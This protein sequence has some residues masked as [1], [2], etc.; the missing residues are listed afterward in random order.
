MDRL[1]YS[2]IA[3]RDLP[4]AAPLPP[5]AFRRTVERLDLPDGARVLDLGCGKATLSAW[6]AERYGATC[7]GVERSPYA[8]ASARALHPWRGALDILEGDL[9]GELPPGPWDLV[10]NVGA[11]PPGGQR[12]AVARW[13]SVLAPGGAL[14]IGDL[15]WKRPP[16]PDF[17]AVLGAG[18][19]ATMELDGLR[20]LG[21]PTHEEVASD[22][23]FRAYELALRG[24]IEAF[25]A[26]HPADPDADA[27][28]DRAR[29]WWEVHERWGADTLGFALLLFGVTA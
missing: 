3:H 27:M 26:E 2:A 29:A 13:S 14:L 1:R 8:L 6:I 22:A 10:V 20:A 9:A 4:F 23:D 28:R 25:V 17:L 19:D 16:D 21:H 15:Y 24:S 5:D 7:I 11:M 18:A 12:E